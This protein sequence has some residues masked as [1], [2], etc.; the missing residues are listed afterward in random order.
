VHLEQQ[1]RPQPRGVE[2]PRQVDHRQLDDVR[3]RSLDGGVE[4]HAFRHLPPVAVV[5]AQVGQVAPPSEHRR[6]VAV[7]GRRDDRRV[8]EGAHLREPL[9]V[10]RDD[11]G[12]LVRRDAELLAEP[13]RGQ[14]VRQPVVDRLGAVAQRPVDRVERQVEHLRGG[15]RVHVLLRGERVEQP[16]VAREVGHDPQLDLGVVGHQQLVEALPRH[17]RPP[18]LAS[19]VAPD[20][21]VL[22]VRVRGRQAPG[23]RD[24]LRQRRVDATRGRVDQRRQRV[25]VGRQQLAELAPLHDRFDDGV[26]T[27]QVLQRARV[28]RVAG[29]DPAGLGQLELVEQ[30]LSAA[31]GPS[32]R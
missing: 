4:R 24:R 3:R 8:E 10:G 19:L 25:H 28:G 23:R 21:D 14:P 18:D 5:G 22:Q 13:E 31:A 20:R 30:H 9:E 1:L 29:L 15:G 11:L 32:R 17:E 12:R 6:G 2:R 26:E 16:L 27:Q 7:V